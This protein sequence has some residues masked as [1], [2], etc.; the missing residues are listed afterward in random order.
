MFQF[1][2]QEKEYYTFYY[3]CVSFP[4]GSVKVLYSFGLEPTTAKK[5][6]KK[7]KNS[8]PAM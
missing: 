7:R 1:F 3:F 5:E 8:Y 4:V 6:R 2:L